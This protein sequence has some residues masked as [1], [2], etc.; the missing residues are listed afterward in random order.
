MFPHW[1]GTEMDSLFY[2]PIELAKSS[3][4]NKVGK[5]KRRGELFDS[6]CKED[7]GFHY[8]ENLMGSPRFVLVWSFPSRDEGSFEYSNVRSG[9]TKYLM[10]LPKEYS[11]LFIQA[12]LI[13]MSLVST[14]PWKIIIIFSAFI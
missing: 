3:F 9:Y 5:K 1:H 14:F 2:R 8:I 13:G 6:F 4:G 11:L 10:E 12:L 7:I